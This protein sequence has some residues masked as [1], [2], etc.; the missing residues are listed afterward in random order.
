MTDTKITSIDDTT[1][2][3]SGSVPADVFDG[4]YKKATNEF[5]S[6]TELKGFRKGNAPEDL[7]I[8]EVGEQVIL[9]RAINLAL[10]DAWPQIIEEHSIDAIG[11]PEFQITKVAKSNPL[12]WKATVATLPEITLPDY[13]AIAKEIKDRETGEIKVSEKEIDDAIEWIRK[14]RE[15]DGKLPEVNEEFVKSL[16]D[17][18]DIA[19]LR[20]MLK[21]N[22]ESEKR[23]KD[24]EPIRVAILTAIREKAPFPIPAPLLASEQ[25][26]MMAELRSTVE[27]I[28]KTWE[29]YVT[30][31]KKS[32]E[33][34]KAELSEEAERRAAFSLLLQTIAKDAEITA[35]NEEMET[36]VQGMLSGYPEEQRKQ[37][38][39]H[40]LH[41][42]VY[43]VIMND[44]VFTL[45][46]GG[47]KTA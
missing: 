28:G 18:K 25:E 21:S 11:R 38:D 37:I 42:Y 26:R 9:E 36:R 47:T 7:V 10:S 32:E 6:K 39:Q 27:R 31:V 30:E 14:S 12:E 5:I 29:E 46:E 40:Q 8:K 35:T 2:E 43:G 1:L 13:A 16:G 20:D 22:L 17:F 3:I 44:K 19:A 24:R 41:E 23:V 45:L 33:E 34:I 4:H 15:K